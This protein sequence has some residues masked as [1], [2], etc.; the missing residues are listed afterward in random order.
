MAAKDRFDRE[1]SARLL[2]DQAP[3]EALVCTH[4]LA[5]HNPDL[6][7]YFVAVRDII[8]IVEGDR[9]PIG[10]KQP[11]VLCP[12]SAEVSTETNVVE[13]CPVEIR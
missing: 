6:T 13:V 5:C 1:L 12:C 2:S 8:R 9:A 11:C 3:V 4:A 7:Q 10:K